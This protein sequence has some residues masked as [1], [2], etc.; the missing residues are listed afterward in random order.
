V[1]PAITAG[2]DLPIVYAAAITA[3]TTVAWFFLVRITGPVFFSQF[4]YFI[5]LGGF[6][7]GYLLE[8]ERHSFYVWI[9]TAMA[10]AGLAIF[11]HGAKSREAPAGSPATVD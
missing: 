1:F 7:W 6:G 10:F 3:V 5:V 4:N 2:G 8:N 9:A 11:T